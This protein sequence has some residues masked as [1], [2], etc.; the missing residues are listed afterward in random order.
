MHEQ[1]AA[2]RLKTCLLRLVRL[3]REVSRLGGE[4][5][6]ALPTSLPGVMWGGMS[7]RYSTTA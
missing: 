6:Q 7:S 3:W 4:C 1:R 5:A 2:K